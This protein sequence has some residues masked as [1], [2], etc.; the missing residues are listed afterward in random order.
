MN[1]FII[2]MIQIKHNFLSMASTQIIYLNPV[3]LCFYMYNLNYLSLRP[4]FGIFL[5]N[6]FWTPPLLSIL[7]MGLT[8]SVLTINLTCGRSARPPSL[9]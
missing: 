3:M 4:N 7:Y 9:S 6:D 2:D 5:E 1:L 8:G